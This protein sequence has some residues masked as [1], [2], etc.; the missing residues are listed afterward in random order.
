[1]SA[2][3]SLACAGTMPTSPL[4][5]SGAH[6]VDHVARHAFSIPDDVAI[7]FEG[8]S[9]TWAGLEDR[10]LRLAAAFAA[11]G[12]GEGDRVAILT[13]NRPEFVETVIAANALRAIAV[14]LNFR[15][16]PAEVAY[17]LGDS[18]ATLIVTDATLEPLARAAIAQ[19]DDPPPVIVA[20]PGYEELIA[21]HD[22]ATPSAA[23]EERDV[24]LIMYTSGT[25]GRPKGAML[26]HLN[27]LL[28]AIT[29]IRTTAALGR[30]RGRAVQRAAVPHRRDRRDGSVAAARRA[31]R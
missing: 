5:F 31:R 12:V 16:A 7:R 19:A 15:L 30:R 28:Q 10:V 2:R 29:A 27:L 4:P 8:S 25:T 11:H 13:T 23:I 20:G 3:E 21:A 1:M 14:P 22:P 9:I 26:T 17:V 24:A 18:G 6:W